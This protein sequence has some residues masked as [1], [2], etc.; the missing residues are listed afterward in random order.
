MAKN[1]KRFTTLDLY[2]SAFLLICGIQPELEVNNGRVIFTF[3]ANGALYEAIM[4]YNSNTEVHVADFVTAT[5]TLKG[6]MLTL[7]DRK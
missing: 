6:Q 2:L 1:E 3:L 4:L 7:R 5:K